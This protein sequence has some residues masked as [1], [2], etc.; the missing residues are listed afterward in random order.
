MTQSAGVQLA[1]TA[2]LRH[3]IEHGRA[4]H[5]VELADTLGIGIGIEEARALQRE[6][7]AAA[8]ASSCWLSHDTDYIEAWGPFSNV[9]THVRIAVDGEER[10]FGL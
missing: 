1:Y 3:F 2:I 4:P 7:A 9:P 10:W 5:Y 6:A 8:P